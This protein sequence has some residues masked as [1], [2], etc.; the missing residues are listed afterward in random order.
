M[1][2]CALLLRH[3]GN[4]REHRS[5]A[6]GVTGLLLARVGSGCCLPLDS[7]TLGGAGSPPGPSLGQ[8]PPPAALSV[9]EPPPSSSPLAS[10]LQHR[11]VSS[12]VVFF[13][14][15]T[16]AHRSGVPSVST[17]LSPAPVSGSGAGHCP[18]GRPAV[19]PI[20]E[21]QG[22]G[23]HHQAVLK[24][25]HTRKPALF[26]MAWGKREGVGPKAHKCGSALRS[27]Q[28][29]DCEGS[30]SLCLPCTDGL[31]FKQNRKA[32]LRSIRRQTGCLALK[33]IATMCALHESPGENGSHPLTQAGS[34]CM[35]ATLACVSWQ[36]DG[37]GGP[38]VV[39][40]QPKPEDFIPE[41]KVH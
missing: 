34:L 35:S 30:S 10:G 18:P 7:D 6:P 28:G 4:H 17:C 19:V 21:E 37:S 36:C 9:Q 15:H 39:P 2:V 3:T 40:H 25:T 31:V 32:G 27:L 24:S 8:P 5:S 29:C 38:R 12:S 23:A 20:E 11:P 1:G 13:L 16:W 22:E 33:L 14:V 41:N 26:L